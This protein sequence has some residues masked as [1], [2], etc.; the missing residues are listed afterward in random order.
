MLTVYKELGQTP[1]QALNRLREVYPEFRDATLSYAGR[2]D[3]MA[4][5]VLLVLVGEENKQRTKYLSLPKR[6]TCEV[7]LGV[8][9]DT[10]DVLGKVL[11]AEDT[12]ANAET[13]STY[14]AHLVGKQNFP[15]P[16]YSSRTVFG[17]PLFMWA[18]EGKL[19]QITIP[20]A[21][22][23]VYSLSVLGRREVRT[24]ALEVFVRKRVSLPTGDFR[25]EDVVRSWEEKVFGRGYTFSAYR[26]ELRCSTGTYVRSLAHHLG[27]ELG[28]GAIALSIVRNSVGEYS[29]TDAVKLYT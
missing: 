21:H 16:P 8:T 1:L 28:T 2:L 11:S 18:R 14:A 6:Y 20:N 15:Y 24:D 13:F 26:I 27:E 29:D 10:Y 4:E 7:L 12:A 19:D 17:K 3:P 25:Q 22:S 23:E 5:G 9:T